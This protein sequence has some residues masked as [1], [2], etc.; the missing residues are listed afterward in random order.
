MLYLFH[1]FREVTDLP[2]VPEWKSL[3]LNWVFRWVSPKL[4]E[5]QRSKNSLIL[6]KETR[7]LCCVRPGPSLEMD[8]VQMIHSGWAG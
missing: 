6:P 3:N 4:R 1:R 5:G 7:R 2:K 8:A